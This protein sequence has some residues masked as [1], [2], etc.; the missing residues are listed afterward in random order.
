MTKARGR[1][2]GKEA[3]RGGE[4]K[5]DIHFHGAPPLAIQGFPATWKQPENYTRNVPSGRWRPIATDRKI[6]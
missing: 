3:A 5:Y 2:R 4:N 1:Q 6:E